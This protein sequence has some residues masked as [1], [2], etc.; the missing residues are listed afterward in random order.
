MLRDDPVESLFIICV[1][2]VVT[3]L[4]KNVFGYIQSTLMTYVEHGVI[5]DLRN[6]VYEH[7][8]RLPLA[9]FSNERTGGLISRVINDVPVIIS[10]IS[11]T[12]FTSVREPLLIVAYLTIAALHQL[13][14][15]ADL[16]CRPA[17]HPCAHGRRS[18]CGCTRRA[19]SFR[20]GSPTLRRCSRRRSPGVKV[21][22]AF[23]ME[24]FESAKFAGGQQGLF[25]TV[26]KVTKVRN[27]AS[28]LSEFLGAVAGAI[29]IWYGGLEV[30]GHGALRASEFL[31]FLFAIFQLMPP[32]KELSTVNNRIQ[33]ATAA[34]KRVFDLLDTEP[35]IKNV[36]HPVV[37]TGFRDCDRFP[38]RELP[39]RERRPCARRHHHDGRQGR[40]RG[41]RRPQRSRENRRWWT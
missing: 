9:F 18:A 35:N 23:G 2:V 6:A 21:V 28:P 25:R 5:R 38:E 14:A 12:F 24:A 3:F 31:G 22:K 40:G 13:E 11:A 27:L 17:V 15:H 37:L 4:L 39:V 26:F 1:I 8:H 20:N 19:G 34:G 30:L 10:G 33:E 7:I 41:H 36:E 32:V 29:V 16:V